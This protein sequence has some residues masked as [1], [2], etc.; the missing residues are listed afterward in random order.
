MYGIISWRCQSCHTRTP[1]RWGTPPRCLLS[2][3]GFWVWEQTKPQHSCTAGKARLPPVFSPHPDHLDSR[4]LLGRDGN[5]GCVWAQ[6][7][8][9]AGPGGSGAPRPQQPGRAPR[10]RPGGGGGGGGGV[11]DS[12]L[13]PGHRP[14]AGIA[15]WGWNSTLGPGQRRQRSHEPGRSVRGRWRGRGGSHEVP[16]GWCDPVRCWR[17]VTLPLEVAFFSCIFGLLRVLAI[18]VF[19]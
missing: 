19:W 11:R 1:D 13:G 4:G 10:F 3:R 5:A 7:R 14:G 6:G 18:F 8:I 16:T 2:L 12:A 17:V 15:P 9:W